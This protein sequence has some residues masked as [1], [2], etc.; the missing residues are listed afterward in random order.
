MITRKEM[1]YINSWPNKTPYPGE[2]YS[3]IILSKL[4]KCFELYNNKY[5]N[6][7]YTIQ[8]SNNEEVDFEIQDKN[9]AH[10]LG[11]DYKNISKD[12]FWDYRADIL[13]IPTDSF[14]SYMLLEKIVDKMD[15]VL[16]YDKENESCS[17]INYYR[18]GIKC[19][20][21][22]KLADLSNFH[23]GCINFNKD[24]Y[25]KNNPLVNF[26][27]QSTKFLYTP[28]DE[29]VSPYFMMGI[30]KD[31]FVPGDQFI[32][33]TLMAVDSPLRFF[34]GQ[35]VIIPT[36]ILT[37]DNGK[38]DKRKAS[39]AE[40]IKLIREYQNIVNEY[41][42]SNNLNIFGDYFSLLMSDKNEDELKL[43]K[44]K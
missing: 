19:D 11:I 42:I 9:V 40:K 33:E 22:S 15:D 5:L 43:A 20:I 44:I 21:F 17:A 8:F 12:F 4:K 16:A 14:S 26:T 36:Q 2:E 34:A 41:N 38:L 23:Y 30:K 32:V 25:D 37:D 35:E 39:S 6:R 10:I 28:S 13:D 24:I 29:V 18:V 1:G 27:P 7:K 31:E 3:A